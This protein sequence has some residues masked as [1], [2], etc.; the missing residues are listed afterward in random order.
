M[1]L[2]VKDEGDGLGVDIVNYGYISTAVRRFG[3][4]FDFRVSIQGCILTP[5]VMPRKIPNMNAII[6]YIKNSGPIR[7]II[8]SSPS[9]VVT[10]SSS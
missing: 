8:Y 6:E 10:S 7:Y 2:N 1:E 9:M 4:D 3:F 5:I